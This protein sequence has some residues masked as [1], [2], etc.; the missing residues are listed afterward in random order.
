MLDFTF[1]FLDL[2]IAVADDNDVVVY[3]NET[4]ANAGESKCTNVVNID[5]MFCEI[6]R[7]I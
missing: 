7:F 5:R 2:H 6:L 4:V 3:H 1:F